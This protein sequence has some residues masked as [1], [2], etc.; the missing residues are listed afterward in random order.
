MIFF[1]FVCDAHYTCNGSC[2]KVVFTSVCLSTG[3]D[4]YVRSQV[5]F[6]GWIYWRQQVYQRAMGIPEGRYN[7]RVGIPEGVGRQVYRRDWVG[8]PGSRQVYQRGGAGIPEG[9]EVG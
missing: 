1:S 9:L 8:T 6:S 2:G 7:R 4:G 3:R 5:P